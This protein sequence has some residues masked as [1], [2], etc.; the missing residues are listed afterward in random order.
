MKHWGMD[1]KLFD[2]ETAHDGVFYCEA[3][4]DELLDDD[5]SDGMF[6][7][8]HA[9]VDL[10]RELLEDLTPEDLGET[11]PAAADA[12]RRQ[13]TSMAATRTSRV[14][15]N[16]IVSGTQKGGDLR[17]TWVS[18]ETQF[19]RKRSHL[20]YEITLHNA[21]C[22]DKSQYLVKRPGKPAHVVSQIPLEVTDFSTAGQANLCDYAP[23]KVPLN[24]DEHVFTGLRAGNG[25]FVT[26]CHD[27]EVA[28]YATSINKCEIEA[29][30]D[31]P[32]LPDINGPVLPGDVED[33]EAAA[34]QGLGHHDQ[35]DRASPVRHTI[36]DFDPG[37]EEEADCQPNRLPT[38]ASRDSV[39]VC[40]DHERQDP[41]P[42]ELG[43]RPPTHSRA[44][45][46]GNHEPSP[47]Y[48]ADIPCNGVHLEECESKSC[49]SR[50]ITVDKC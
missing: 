32:V 39:H 11:T 35:Q 18:L 27:D 21:R 43:D 10:Y 16:V 45:P 34:H 50:Y 2:I 19:A 38:P 37:D 31:E 48:T 49:H 44:S 14:V 28:I 8:T 46:L 20:S 7:C 17:V 25:Y 29:A 3:M 5:E 22:K 4:Q 6:C 40:D 33:E 36:E 47:L 15:Q 24:R 30:P 23:V 42:T 13:L 41:A 1:K 9:V 12:K 26:I